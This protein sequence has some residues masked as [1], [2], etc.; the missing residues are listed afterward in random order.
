MQK[1]GSVRRTKLPSRLIRRLWYAGRLREV[2]FHHRG[3]RL[4]HASTKLKYTTVVPAIR[5]DQPIKC[6]TTVSFE[7]MSFDRME[8]TKKTHWD[9]DTAVL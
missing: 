7:R 2:V 5:Q 8:V 3:V 4:R 6:E 1:T 9:S